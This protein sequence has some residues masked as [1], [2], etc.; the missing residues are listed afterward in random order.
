MNK[1]LKFLVAFVA[2]VI[3]LCFFKNFLV[4][5]ALSSGLSK[6]AH[7]PVKIGS[8]DVK[9]ISSSIRLKNISIHNPK[10]YPEKVMLSAPVV[11]IDF[12][13]KD[14]MQGKAHFK[15]VRLDL[16]EVIVIKNKDGKLN[17]DALK[18]TPQEKEKQKKTK[19]DRAKG[20][21]PKLMIDNLY[22]S[23]GRV[24]YKD[25]SKGGE[26]SIQEFNIDIK[27]RQFKHIDNPSSV[28]SLIMFE[29]LTHTTLSR[30]AN[31]DL[32]MF[33]DGAMGV[34]SEGLGLVGD[35]ANTFEDTA[36]SVAGLF[37]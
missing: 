36:K 6:A 13:P 7:V 26:P 35:G 23:I 33:K 11:F 21:A 24:V 4:Q 8:T 12:E 22:L 3:L 25:Y 2:V 18:P 32:S 28:V 1:T 9:F 20:K 10:G 27:E 16:K 34:L 31:L 37:K 19:E 17:I 14:L 29:A 15:E 30:L 5:S